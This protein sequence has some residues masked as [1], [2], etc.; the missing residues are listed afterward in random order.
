MSTDQRRWSPNR[1]FTLVEMLTVVAILGL[2]IV[3]IGYEFDST[4]GSYFHDRA[5]MDTQAQSRLVMTKVVNRLRGASPWEF[6]SNPSPVPSGQ[7]H[8]VI[9]YPVPA[10]TPA[11][12]ATSL[13]FYRPHPGSLSLATTVP[14]SSGGAPDPPYDVVT[15]Q[16]SK[17]PFVGCKDPSPNYLVETAVDGVT[18]AQSETPVVLG[19]NVTDFSVSAQGTVS[20]ALVTVSITVQNTAPGCHPAVPPPSPPPFCNYTAHDT[21]WVGGG[22]APSTNE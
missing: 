21:V 4:I 3:L 7:P 22:D 1:G 11:P 13:T 8:A 9:I 10:P 12:T 5:N 17:C 19:S 16:R 15:I 14:L 18:N 6:A 20:P 2:I